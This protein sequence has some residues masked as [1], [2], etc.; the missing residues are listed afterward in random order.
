MNL[1]LL[2]EDFDDKKPEQKPRNKH[3]NNKVKFCI[4]KCDRKMFIK[5]GKPVIHCPSCD[6]TFEKHSPKSV[7]EFVGQLDN[8][9]SDSLTIGVGKPCDECNCYAES[10]KCGCVKC[11]KMQKQGQIFKP[12]PIKLEYDSVS[13]SAKSVNYKK[14][15]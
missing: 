11:K 10:C 8:S 2:F 9:S 12:E 6:R 3:K 1:I 5:D 7:E 15:K 4:G 14:G 13:K